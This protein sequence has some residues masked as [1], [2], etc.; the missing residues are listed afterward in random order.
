M[1]S[2]SFSGPRQAQSKWSRV[3]A[4]SGGAAV[5]LSDVSESREKKWKDLYWRSNKLRRAQQLGME[6]PHKNARHQAESDARANEPVNLLFVCSK[7]QWRS[8]TGEQ[9]YRDH[10]QVNTRSA[11]TASSARHQ[12]SVADIKWAD[13]ILVMERKHAQ[14]LRADYPEALQFKDLVVLDIPDNY[15]FM[16]PA[17]ID[18]LRAAVDPILASL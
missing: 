1:G 6:E 12:V 9:I 10:P 17:L 7:N 14:R 2:A 13:L 5:C 8:P 11:G 15:R 3:L 4:S 18:E 16:N